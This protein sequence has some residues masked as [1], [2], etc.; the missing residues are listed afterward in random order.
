MARSAALWMTI[1][2]G[3]AWAA[4]ATAADLPRPS[5]YTASAPL[6][7]Y[8]WTGPYLGGNLGY[9]WGST[10]NN[11]TRPSGFA[12]GVEGGYNWQTGPLVFGGEAD[13]QLSNAN[14]MFAPWKFSNPWFGTVR[15][16][17]G[18]AISNVLIY[19]TAGFALGEL[20]AETVGLASENHANVGWT[21]GAGIEAGFAA[22]WSAKIEYLFVDL[23]S[24]NFALT[25]TSNGLSASLFRVG[26]NYHF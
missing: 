20:S 12:G 1:A 13:L 5:Y 9:E 4:A 22:N 21:A 3:A 25:G 24:N 2:A 19:A 23:A 7:G 15:G 6:S 10:S 17:A 11:P 16:R 18:Y 8:S 26:V 14:D